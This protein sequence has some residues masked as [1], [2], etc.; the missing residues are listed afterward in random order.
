[1]LEERYKYREATAA[2][3]GVVRQKSL[4]KMKDKFSA[5][6]TI[7]GMRNKEVLEQLYKVLCR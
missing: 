1:M 5:Q 3:F 4:N 2:E 7:A 6:S